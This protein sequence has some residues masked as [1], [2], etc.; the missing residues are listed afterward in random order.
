M[1][2][3][4]PEIDGLEATRIIRTSRDLQPVIIAMTANAMQGDREDCLAGGMNDYLSKPVRPEEL[5]EMLEKWGSRIKT[6]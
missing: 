4:M 6:G 1:D 2:I 3:Q 5:V